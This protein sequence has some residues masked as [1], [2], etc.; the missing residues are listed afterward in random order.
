MSTEMK[1]DLILPSRQKDRK[2]FVDEVKFELDIRRWSVLGLLSNDGEL[3]N[4][5]QTFS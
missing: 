1:Q 4:L 5:N 3:G 2:C